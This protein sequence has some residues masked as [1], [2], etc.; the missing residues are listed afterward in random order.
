MDANETLKATGIGKEVGGWYLQ[1]AYDI[2]PLIKPGT[3]MSLS[4]FLRYEQYNT[5]KE[6]FS[7]TPDP[8][9]D[10]TV[11]TFGVGFK[12]HPNVVIKA[13]YQWKDTESDNPEGTASGQDSNK[14]DQF[15]L[16]IGFI[17]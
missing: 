5:N 2:F 3:E 1:L 12:P 8:T 6:V 9:L 10:I 15:N 14:I 13:D 7:G 4:P 17:F 16:G 11:T